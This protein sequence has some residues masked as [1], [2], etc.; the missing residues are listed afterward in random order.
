LGFV[1]AGSL[2][3]LAF[4][5]LACLPSTSQAGEFVVDTNTLFLA[6]FNS[7][8]DADFANGTPKLSRGAS[9]LTRG[10]G[11][12]YGEALVCKDGMIT[13]PMG[14]PVKFMQLCFA[15][16][17]NL[18]LGKGTLEF[19]IKCSFSRKVTDLGHPSLYYL[20]DIPTKVKDANG[21]QKR[22]S[23][24]VRETE[25]AKR[26]FHCFLGEIG[27]DNAKGLKIDWQA[28][29][30]H[31]VAVTWDHAE[32]H[33]FLDGV[34]GSSTPLSNGIFGSERGICEGVFWVG[35]LSNS[36]DVHDGLIDELRI[37]SSVRY[38][39]D[40]MPDASVKP[41]LTKP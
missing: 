6:H 34:K 31:H 38:R 26:F 27:V 28:G 7:T 3:L 36:G 5:G 17:D 21:V 29:E 23:L 10:G 33:L 20:F 32:G 39:E 11:G 8:T 14:D 4:L 19:W 1:T 22:M 35:G 16:D 40:F 24:V 15:L 18:D 2:V 41:K 25:D 12:K 9:G 37:S 30:W 13:S